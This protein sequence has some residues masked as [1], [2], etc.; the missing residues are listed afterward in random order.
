MKRVLSVLLSFVMLLSVT[1]SLDLTAFASTYSGTCGDNVTWLF[2]TDTGI[3]TISGSGDMTNYSSKTSIPWY[4]YNTYVK[5]V[6][7]ADRIAS[8]G[9]YAFYGCSN[10]TK[11]NY[12]GTIDGWLS[13]SFT[14]SYSNPIY[15]SEN[16]YLDDI[17]QENIMADCKMKLNI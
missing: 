3:L 16:L 8:I 12:L 11:T 10:L 5:T 13:I 14:S 4:K 1:S 15:Y 9:D 6:I 7:I 17:L 2:N